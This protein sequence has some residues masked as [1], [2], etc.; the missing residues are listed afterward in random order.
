M[1]MHGSGSA[2]MVIAM[3]NRRIPNGFDDRGPI[4]LGSTGSPT[5]RI[6]VATIP[7]TPRDVSLQTRL[8]ADELFMRW[9]SLPETET[10]VT[11][12]VKDFEQS[13]NPL[14]HTN[15][16]PILSPRSPLHSPRGQHSPR[17]PRSSNTDLNFGGNR[18]R[19]DSPEGREPSRPTSQSSD[20]FTAGCE[21]ARKDSSTLNRA[22]QKL[23]ISATKT[24]GPDSVE[25][26][27]EKSRS[28]RERSHSSPQ[29]IQRSPSPNSGM[30]TPIG[31]G[32]I[33]L[34]SIPGYEN[35]TLRPGALADQIPRFFF[36]LGRG[37]TKRDIEL[38]QR[39]LARVRCFFT[40][41][42]GSGLGDSMR[43]L[44]VDAFTSVTQGLGLSR[45]LNRCLFNRCT[46]M[47]VSS[48]DGLRPSLS[49][50]SM[51]TFAGLTKAWKEICLTAGR[52][53]AL[54]T[55]WIIHGGQEPEQR[56]SDGKKGYD[57]NGVTPEDLLVVAQEVVQNHPG[58]AFLKETP[59]FQEKYMETVVNRIFYD[60]NRSWSGKI[61][62]REWEMSNVT[63][64][65][66]YLE[67]ED[68][69]NQILDYFSYEHFYVIYTRFLELDTDHDFRITARDLTRY[70]DGSLSPLIVERIVNSGAVK[71][72][73]NPRDSLNFDEFVWFILSVEHKSHPTAREYWFRCMDLD[74]DGLL[75]FYELE[76]MYSQQLERLDEDEQVPF[77][78]M[79]C[80]M[81]DLI[82]PAQ[83]GYV[84]LS[85]IKH[86][87]MA[88][89]FFD[90]FFDFNKFIENEQ[91]DSR[92]RAP[93][94]SEE[95]Q[96]TEWDKFARVE[97]DRLAAEGEYG[98]GSY[99]TDMGSGDYYQG[100]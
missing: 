79:L 27:A 40:S 81:L 17:S 23:Q 56:S 55:F 30:R 36:P 67:E 43:R 46:A 21:G 10:M 25:S 51:V 9:L 22:L 77:E 61:S 99:W 52:N 63:A 84:T 31:D 66:K 19:T 94:D 92:N 93:Q 91:R 82:K 71:R 85:D 13:T 72:K 89:A 12:L 7:S 59:E 70:D 42:G 78:D 74:G 64:I 5:K 35:A 62:E 33:F 44:T 32:S 54:R 15:L 4:R 45:Y 49:S 76:Q 58:L 80:Q 2:P 34:I 48:T 20:S 53:E 68:D 86:C 98:D 3:E 83:D 95:M 73:D 29:P 8:K 16:Q 38:A 88:D 87:N 11:S 47:E 6:T 24:K 50:S 97:Y 100:L 75:S 96:L 41:T 1:S 90:V 57:K 26:A 60:V 69:I 39:D 14:V 28:G 37:N 18:L 65:L